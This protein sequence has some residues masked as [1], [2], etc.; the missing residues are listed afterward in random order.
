MTKHFIPLHQNNVSYFEDTNNMSAR[1][2]LSGKTVKQ[3]RK[4]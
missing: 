1:S 3:L 4:G 2:I